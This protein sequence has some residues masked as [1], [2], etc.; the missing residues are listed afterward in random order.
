MPSDA[1]LTLDPT[2]ELDLQATSDLAP[3]ATL[4]DCL[5]QSI[6]RTKEQEL[7]PQQ[8]EAH[9]TEQMVTAQH[10]QTEASEGISDQV[11]CHCKANVDALLHASRNASSSVY[12]TA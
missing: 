7:M 11:C 2:Y 5:G 12:D 8:A 6:V 3:S 9:A 1:L 4:A 10:T